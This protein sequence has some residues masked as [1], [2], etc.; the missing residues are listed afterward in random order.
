MLNS[1]P[2]YK[3]E[4][5]ENLKQLLN[6]SA[7][8]YS[9]NIAFKIKGDENKYKEVSYSQF[10]YE[11]SALGT[12][13]I[14]LGLKGKK[15]A[16]ISENRYEWCVSYLATV[17]GTG[18]VVP[19]D[20]LLTGEEIQNLL[21]RSEAEAVI[22]S[23]K[24]VD[25]MRE[26]K[27]ISS[28]LK[29]Y[30]LMDDIENNE[31]IS[32]KELLEEGKTLLNDGHREFVD[33]PIENKVMNIILFT[34]GTT[35]DSKAVM[36]SHY[37][38]CSNI[39]AT[40]S[41]VKVRS[42][43]LLLSFL[44]LHHT[45]ECTIG[46]LIAIYRGACIFHSAGLKYLMKELKEVRPTIVVCVPL[47]FENMHK[48]VMEQVEKKG[49]TDKI[50]KAMSINRLLLK[51]KI[52]ISKKLFK[53]VYDNF[54]GRIRLFICGAS[55]LDPRVA[56]DF[57][58]MGIRLL[59]GYG[60]TETSPLVAGATDKHIRYD[61]PGRALPNVEV[62]IDNPN[63]EGIGELVVKG[64]NVMLGYYKN[65]EAT[66]EVLKDGWFYTGD[67][68]Y[69]DKDNSIVITGR[70]KSVIVLKNGKNVF[71]EELEKLLNSNEFV[72]ESFIW[73]DEDETHSTIVAAKIVPN[74]EKLKEVFGNLSDLQIKEKIK[75]IVRSINS[76]IPSYK[77]IRKFN[78]S[79]V[80]LIKT[81]TQKIKRYEELKRIKK[82]KE[83]KENQN[84]SEDN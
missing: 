14:D 69:L 21:S 26:N 75:S 37:N 18:V 65:P 44:P 16:V 22:F 13:L 45:Y 71:P 9:N 80:E 61:A 76:R 40:C 7:A 29:Y 47:L 50:N 41:T 77:A 8:K 42:N 30:I 58:S 66:S 72:K 78:I 68:G 6:N 57:N 33:A 81:T 11:V 43:D 19:L 53:Q 49:L 54:G 51:L 1:K 63:E 31:F 4:Y 82:E 46:F 79:A 23:Q 5:I 59:Q 2:I 74:F 70:Q 25:V 52:N 27:N 62:R 67:L 3:V 60:L 64:P 84:I 73:G 24:Y 15:I 83:A 36:L 48:K 28:I 10:N 20:K 55:A 39:M 32:Y 34:S 35:A 56:K 12:K 17:C 38:I